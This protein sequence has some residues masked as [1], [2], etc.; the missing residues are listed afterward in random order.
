MKKSWWNLLNFPR[1]NIFSKTREYSGI[2]I[3]LSELH[4]TNFKGYDNNTLLHHLLKNLK[5]GKLTLQNRMSEL[6]KILEMF[7][8]TKRLEQNPEDRSELLLNIYFEKRS[9]KLFS[10][11]YNFTENIIKNKKFDSNSLGYLY[12]IQRLAAM[13]NFS[14]GNYEDYR[15]LF[16]GKMKTRHLFCDDYLLH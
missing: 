15:K 6:Y 10:Y 5:V 12:E 8:M 16:S 1:P 2:L 3:L 9:G 11:V 4:K 7:L 14:L 13:N